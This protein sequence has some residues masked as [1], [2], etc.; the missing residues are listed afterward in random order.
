[1]IC[2]RGERLVC[3]CRWS[4]RGFFN[5]YSTA[6]R[7]NFK[8]LLLYLS[9]GCTS[10]HIQEPVQQCVAFADGIVLLGETRKEI[11]MMLETWVQALEAYGFHLSRRQSV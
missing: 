2:M 1:M 3:E 11:N 10:A 6:P 8:L 7:V 5:N 4:N 9:L